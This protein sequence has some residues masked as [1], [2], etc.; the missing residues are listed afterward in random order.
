MY[1][2]ENRLLDE[3]RSTS[4]GFGAGV[5]HSVRYVVSL[6]MP[7]SLNYYHKSVSSLPGRSQNTTARML[8]V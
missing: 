2:L 3:A 8:F 7:H 1:L 4:R 5:L 6:F